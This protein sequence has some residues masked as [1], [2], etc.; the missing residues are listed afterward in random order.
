MVCAATVSGHDFYFGIPS[1]VLQPP[2]IRLI[3]DSTFGATNYTVET[4]TEVIANRGMYSGVEQIILNDNLQVSTS[5]YSDRNKGIRVRTT[6]EYPISVVV[7]TR[8]ST[9]VP[10]AYDNFKIHQNVE[11]NNKASYEYFALSTDYNG[12]S[13]VNR[14][15][16]VLLIANH[17][18]TI[19]SITPTQTASLPQD[20]QDP[21][22][23]LVSVAPGSTHNV[24]LNQFQTLLVFNS[25]LDITGTRIV[26]NKP[27]TV[28][29]GHQ[30]AQFPTASP[31][32]EPVHVQVPPS[33][34]WGQKFLLAPFA[35]RSSD[36]H[37]KL[38]TAREDTAIVYK[39]GTAAAMRRL[40]ESAGQGEYLDF[41]SGSYCSLAAT[42]PIFVVQLG[43][44]YSTDISGDP[45][46]AV[47]SPTNRHINSTTFLTGPSDQFSS[48]FISIT[49]LAEH[50]NNNQSI[51]LNGSV[52][53]CSWTE[54]YNTS[55]IAGYVC[56]LSIGGVDTE[57]HTVS[58]SEEDGLLSVVAYGWNNSPAWGYAYLTGMSLALVEFQGIII[59]YNH[60]CHFILCIFSSEIDLQNITTTRLSYFN[61][62]SIEGVKELPRE[63][64]ASSPPIYLPGFFVFGNLVV[65]SVYV[66]IY[67]MHIHV[68]V[69][70]Y[71][72]L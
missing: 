15:S 16:E 46:M 67:P 47:V 28:L 65:T 9:L 6:G 60:L 35:G 61:L 55:G 14:K 68:I 25:T 13:F 30:C 64:E 40:L 18:D 27:L 43:A 3:I 53:Q 26:S 39:C 22:S 69:V 50:F 58:H 34:L 5:E 63:L 31:F 37:Y 2:E 24:T 17:K 57:T 29:T 45:V 59:I 11:I 70:M 4:S 20:A 52:V 49:V 12:Q 33:F 19:V 32:C 41:P 23:D 42:K 54:I 36:Q 51:L 10:L 21:S 66:S 48:S 62:S 1:T 38:V 71:V 56:S 72:H 7:V 44:G 8:I